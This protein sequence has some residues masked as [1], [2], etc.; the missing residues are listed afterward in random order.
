MATVAG[1][2]LISRSLAMPQT[3]SGNSP[4]HPKEMVQTT[5]AGGIPPAVVCLTFQ[6]WFIRD[7]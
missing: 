1:Y 6:R 3:A 2:T 4:L 7:C 5:T